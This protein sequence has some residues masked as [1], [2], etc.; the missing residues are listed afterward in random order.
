[1]LCGSYVFIRCYFNIFHV[2]LFFVHDKWN[3]HVQTSQFVSL[4]TI[5]LVWTIWYLCVS[6]R[7]VYVNPYC[8]IFIEWIWWW[9]KNSGHENPPDWKNQ[10]TQFEHTQTHL[11]TFAI[12]CLC[13]YDGSLSTDATET[14]RTT[15]HQHIYQCGSEEHLTSR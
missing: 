13:N 3:Q 5:G 2:F 6:D 4:S 8:S 12:L 11:S 14:Q 9:V 10:V 7:I 15:T 1:M